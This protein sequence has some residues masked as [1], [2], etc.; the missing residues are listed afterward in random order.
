MK[1]YLVLSLACLSM[2]GCG[3]QHVPRVLASSSDPVSG[4][5]TQE[6]L[7]QFIALEPIDTHTHIYQASPVFNAMLDKLHIHVVDILVA[8]TPDQKDLD[9]ERKQAWNFVNSSAGHASLCSTFDPFVYRDKSF[10]KN[11][12]TELDEDFAH[13][14]VAVKIWKNIGEQVKDDKGDYI[15]PDN[16]AFQPIYKNIAAHNKTLI[17]H[18]A[19]PNTIWEP[20]NRAAPD[21]GYYMH[22]PEWYMYGKPNAPSKQA[23]LKARDHM[24]E[25]NPHLRVVG[26]HLG[27]MEAD[28][29]Q[30]GDH[31][32]RYPNFAVDIAARMSYFVMQPRALITAFIIKHQDKLI[33]ATDDEFDANSKADFVARHWENGYAFDWRFLATDDVLLYQ[34]HTVRGL[35]LPGPI[36]Q[37][38]YHDNAVRW[39]PG[40]FASAKQPGN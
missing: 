33:Y 26:A 17:A 5:F 9:L 31:L 8:H 40:L 35:A 23:I 13:G 1:N 6:E 3:Y 28:F 12:N 2:A 4:A 15:L 37:K 38:L 20:P 24:L 25:Q 10:A 34:G 22:N 18:V 36:L 11:A 39:F 30:L 7:Q 16:L 29:S 21:Y 19:D 14:A 32:D 27:S